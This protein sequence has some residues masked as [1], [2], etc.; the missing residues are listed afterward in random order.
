MSSGAKVLIV[1]SSP[2]QRMVISNVIRD[3]NMQVVDTA[4]NGQEALDKLQQKE[5]DIVV[6]AVNMPQYDGKYLVK[7]LMLQKSIPILLICGSQDDFSLVTE[8]IQLGAVD[9]IEKPDGGNFSSMRS[10]QDQILNKISTIL[11]LDVQALTE[12]KNATASSV[13]AEHSF[14]DNLPYDI[15][16]IGSST[17]G[18]SAVEALITNLPGNFPL[19][20]IIVQHMPQR[21]I[22]VFAKRLGTLTKIPV[23]V[24][25]VNERILPG[26]IYVAQGIGNPYLKMSLGNLKLNYNNDVYPEFNNPS[27]NCLFESAAP[28]FKNKLLGVVLTGMGKDGMNGAIKI[29]ANNGTMVVQNEKSSVVFGMPKAV[30]DAGCADH[31]VDIRQM[32]HFLTSCL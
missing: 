12:K 18:P 4:G 15:L 3:G 26:N 5:V 24:A 25:E 22:P 32:G 8:C 7:K 28:I 30:I 19:P 27:V 1:D 17:G 29:K 23:K 13:T 16:C 21:F 2:L 6:T 14:G 11:K 20:T 31:V 9:F 10:I